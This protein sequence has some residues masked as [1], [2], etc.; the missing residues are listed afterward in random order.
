MTPTRSLPLI[1]DRRARLDA[2][3]LARV[4]VLAAVVAVLGLPGG[5]SVFGD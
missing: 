5:I 2:T 4:A 3:D 1:A